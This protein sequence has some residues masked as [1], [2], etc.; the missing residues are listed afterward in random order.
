MTPVVPIFTASRR[1]ASNHHRS[2]LAAADVDALKATSAEFTAI[3]ILAI[4]FRGLLAVNAGAAR[5]LAD[6][7]TRSRNS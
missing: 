6:R 7:R 3:D 5:C 1:L 4:R 2:S